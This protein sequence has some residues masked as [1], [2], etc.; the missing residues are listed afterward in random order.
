[1]TCLENQ[2]VIHWWEV[3]LLPVQDG[4]R[5]Q[6]AELT[7][8]TDFSLVFQYPVSAQSSETGPAIPRSP[9]TFTPLSFC[10]TFQNR[11]VKSNRE[12]VAGYNSA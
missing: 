7:A 3:P 11:A 6:D 1:M 9:N 12:G 10:A 8:T 2:L 5:S 4:I